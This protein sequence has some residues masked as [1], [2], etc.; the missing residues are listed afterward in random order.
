MVH[1][2]IHIGLIIIFGVVLVPVYAMLVAWF[3]EQ[4]R[5]LRRSVLGVGYL[6][7]FIIVLL[8]GTWIAGIL[9]GIVMP[10]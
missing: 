9:F 7:G 3:I 1:E 5:D 10:I 8:A 4:P 2:T 6:M